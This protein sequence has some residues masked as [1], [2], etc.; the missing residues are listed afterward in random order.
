MDLQASILPRVFP[1]L[2]TFYLT[3][4]IIYKS[5][6]YRTSNQQNTNQ[7]DVFNGGHWERIINMGH[8]GILL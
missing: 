5:N 8:S 3:T 7:S 4:L 2:S 1:G 6:L